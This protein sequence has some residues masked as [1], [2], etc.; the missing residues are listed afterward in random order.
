VRFLADMGISPYTVDE[1]R[2]Q[3]HDAIHLVEQALKRLADEDIL[4]KARAEERI[5]LTVDL[6][7]AQLSA[8]S[9]EPFPSVI[10]FRLGNVAREVLEV[11]LAEVLIQ[12]ERDLRMGAIIS[13]GMK[14]SGLEVC[15]YKFL[16]TLA[17][18]PKIFSFT[19]RLLGINKLQIYDHFRCK[20]TMYQ[21]RF[22]ERLKISP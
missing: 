8:A 6:D 18:L 9:G 17:F 3:G 16:E 14:L 22:F 12:C 2:K 4:L 1:L 10:L 21:S 7:F 15:R 5:L 20:L 13:F 19:E 11:R